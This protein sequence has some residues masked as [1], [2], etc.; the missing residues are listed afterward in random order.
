MIYNA[1]FFVQPCYLPAWFMWRSCSRL[2]PAASGA[3]G[4]R[5][6]HVERTD[7]NKP[8]DRSVTCLLQSLTSSLHRQHSRCLMVQGAGR[9]RG[10]GQGLKSDEVTPCVELMFSPWWETS[11]NINWLWHDDMM[12]CNVC[13]CG[14]E[15]STAEVML[16]QETG[17]QENLIHGF[18]CGRDGKRFWDFK[19]FDIYFWYILVYIYII[20]CFD[21]IWRYLTYKEGDPNMMVIAS[22]SQYLGSTS[23]LAFVAWALSAGRKPLAHFVLLVKGSKRPLILGEAPQAQNDGT[24]GKIAKSIS[25]DQCSSERF[26]ECKTEKCSRMAQELGGSFSVAVSSCSFNGFSCCCWRCDWRRQVISRASST[27]LM[28]DVFWSIL[29]YF[30]INCIILQK[31]QSDLFVQ[32]S[33]CITDVKTDDLMLPT[34]FSHDR[35]RRALHSVLGGRKAA[36]DFDSFWSIFRVTSSTTSLLVG[37]QG[38]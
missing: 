20:F 22:M 9:N 2:K 17:T 6:E 24:A 18:F 26:A 32:W 14:Q 28:F 27:C 7:R 16:D 38:S 15:A 12:T 13:L 23:L 1:V 35:C 33:E 10:K 25:V 31:A 19:N 30:G 4:E 21:K 8:K 11:W 29:K 5:G 34:R 3:D 36:H 37:H